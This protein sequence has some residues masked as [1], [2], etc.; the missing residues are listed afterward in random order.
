[1]SWFKV[2]RHGALKTSQLMSV[3]ALTSHDFTWPCTAAALAG[4]LHQSLNA[5]CRLALSPNAAPG[6]Y[7]GAGGGAGGGSEG[8]GAG[9]GIGGIGGGALVPQMQA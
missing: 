1:M 2:A 4:S 7:G 5:L 9:G 8:G 3:T 6:R